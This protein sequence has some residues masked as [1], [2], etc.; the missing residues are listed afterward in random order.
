MT[1]IL[2]NYS[3][4][5]TAFGLG[6]LVFSGLEMAMHSMMDSSCLTSIA[7]IH[8]ILHALFTFLQMH[9]LFVNSQV[10]SLLP[11]HLHHLSWRKKEIEREEGDGHGVYTK[12][13]KFT[14]A[15]YT[16]NYVRVRTSYVYL[17]TAYAIKL[18]STHQ[19]LPSVINYLSEAVMCVIINAWIRDT[20]LARNVQLLRDHLSSFLFEDRGESRAS[21][22]ARKCIIILKARVGLIDWFCFCF[23]FF[24]CWLKNSA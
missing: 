21:R 5:F 3:L 11:Y 17:C 2:S 18:L 15:L 19:S 14:C 12:R 10:K 24:R 22:L 8:P 23:F 6:T 1:T 16:V 9:F 20:N 4:R 13:R 7:F